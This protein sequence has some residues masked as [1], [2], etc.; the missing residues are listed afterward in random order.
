MY[1]KLTQA[2]AKGHDF[3]YLKRI[4]KKLLQGEAKRDRETLG[5]LAVHLQDTF[6]WSTDLRYQA[7]RLRPRDARRFFDAVRAIRDVCARS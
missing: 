7:G 2:G 6:T 3:E 4:L 5:A 1:E